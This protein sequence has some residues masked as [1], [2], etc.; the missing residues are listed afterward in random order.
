MNVV[1]DESESSQQKLMFAKS[2]R[3]CGVN[4]GQ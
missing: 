1:V 4:L 3:F 2:Q